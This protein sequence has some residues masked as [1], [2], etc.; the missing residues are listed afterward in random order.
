MTLM[1]E[2]SLF[3]IAVSLVLMVFV[4]SV[5]TILGSTKYKLTIIVAA[6]G[7]AV[8]TFVVISRVLSWLRSVYY[9]RT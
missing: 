5:L 8:A 3:T 7:L 4:G 6:I 2:E 9:S 1:D